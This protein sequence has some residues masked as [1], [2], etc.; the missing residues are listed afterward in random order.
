MI[1]MPDVERLERV[2][3]EFKKLS[4]PEA[5]LPRYPDEALAD[6]IDRS[7]CERIQRLSDAFADGRKVGEMGLGAGLC[8]QGFSNEE[9]EQWLRGFMAGAA[10]ILTRRASHG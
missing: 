9:R 1:P 2:L 8:P 7:E 3:A 10:E 4:D 5:T 6:Y